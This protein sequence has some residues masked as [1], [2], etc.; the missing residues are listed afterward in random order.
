MSMHT[1]ACFDCLKTFRR[2]PSAGFV[3]CASCGQGCSHLGTKT[4]I[5]R[6]TDRKAWDALIERFLR[7]DREV[8]REMYES[9]VAQAH[10]V[11]REIARI[12]AMPENA[13]RRV[14]LRELKKRLARL[15]GN[16]KGIASMDKN[17]RKPSSDVVDVRADEPERAMDQFTAGL[18]T[19]LS[20]TKPAIAVSSQKRKAK[21]TRSRLRRA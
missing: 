8:S 13:G 16:A 11:E 3:R 14:T 1:W 21:A 4:P 12:D 18:R 9:R 10:R 20:A 19:V 15:G 2:E 7:I 17:P 5:P 6:R